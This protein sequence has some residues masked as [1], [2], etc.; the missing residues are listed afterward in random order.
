MRLVILALVSALSVSTAFAEEGM[1][2]N[3]APAAAEATEAAPAEA[4]PAKKV[5]KKQRKLQRK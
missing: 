1:P 5:K 4:A 2:M 3:E